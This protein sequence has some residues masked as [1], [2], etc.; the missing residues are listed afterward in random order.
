MVPKC[1]AIFHSVSET[2]K[3]IRV[4][5]A[6]RNSLTEC[7]DLA[8][9]VRLEA[10]G[11]QSA[12]RARMSSVRRRSGWSA[13]NAPRLTA[14]AEH[15]ARRSPDSEKPGHEPT[16]RIRSRQSPRS[17]P[18]SHEL[19]RTISADEDIRLFSDALDEET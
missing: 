16:T 15:T 7:T 3:L 13:G 14:D 17:L 2:G 19:G 6:S 1:V 11:E 9:A 5:V 10:P 12:R 8:V 4:S 18:N